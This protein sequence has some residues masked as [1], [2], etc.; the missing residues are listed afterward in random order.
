M[1]SNQ[2]KTIAKLSVL[3]AVL[4]VITAITAGCH[5]V[6]P[7]NLSIN[8]PTTASIRVDL[9]GVTAL[10]KVQWQNNVKPDDYWKPNSPIRNGALERTLTNDF[11]VGATWAVSKPNAIWDKWF[12]YHATDLMIMADL[13]GG[14]YDNS[15]FDRRR[16]F[17]P[18]D[19]KAWKA[20]DQTLEIRVEDNFIRVLTKE[21]PHK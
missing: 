4:A 3:F 17:L 6:G 19:S 9:L 21:R 14:P 7:W 15:A 16:I 18:R 13:P 5:G 8:K 20:K 1:N 12:S 11:Q 2:I 10:E